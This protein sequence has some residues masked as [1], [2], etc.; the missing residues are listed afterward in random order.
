MVRRR[1]RRYRDPAT[2]QL[3]EEVEEDV[4]PPDWRAAAW[5]LERRHPD[6]F[7]RPSQ[8]QVSGPDG[9]PVEIEQTPGLAALA[10][11]VAESLAEY[12]AEL[13]GLDDEEE[14]H[15]NTVTPS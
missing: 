6:G 15:A 4:A 12:R 9:G 10:E 5:V 2:G 14:V 3:V 13:E 8:L 11:R 7:A 1:T